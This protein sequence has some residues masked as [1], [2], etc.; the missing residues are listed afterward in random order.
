MALARALVPFAL[1]AQ[2]QARVGVHSNDNLRTCARTAHDS[3]TTTH[4]RHNSHAYVRMHRGCAARILEETTKR[5]A[6]VCGRAN[7]RCEIVRT[8]KRKGGHERQKEGGYE[9]EECVGTGT[10]GQGKD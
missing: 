9:E 2:R 3:C 1:Y 10:K 8:R 4:S 5:V 6:S 7:G